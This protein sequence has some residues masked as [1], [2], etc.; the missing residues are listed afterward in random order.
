MRTE[1][2]NRLARRVTEDLR[3]NLYIEKPRKQRFEQATDE[4][5]KIL[6]IIGPID[7]NGEIDDNLVDAVVGIII[8]LS[9]KDKYRMGTD[10]EIRISCLDMFNI[11][12]EIG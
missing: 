10:D 8:C 7:I 6:Q 4:L 11:K 1:T 9:F 5:R 2:I 12:K 3:Q